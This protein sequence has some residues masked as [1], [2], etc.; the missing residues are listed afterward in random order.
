VYSGTSAAD[1]GKSGKMLPD[2]LYSDEDLTERVNHELRR[3]GLGYELRVSR[4]ETSAELQDVFALRLVDSV[5]GVNVN[6]TDVGFGVSQ[7]LPVIVQSLMGRQQ[8]LLVEQPEI[9]LHPR[10][11]GELAELLASSINLPFGNVFVV[12]SHSEHMILRTQRLIRQGK[13]DPGDVSVVYADR[14]E[15]GTR[16]LPLRLDQS[17]HFIDEWPHGFFEEGFREI[18]G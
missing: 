17:G 7:V 6:L 12:E 15:S 10:L 3:F 13:L 2:V 14:T 18:F 5:T 11:Q 8:V 1:V 16:L 9:H 4:G